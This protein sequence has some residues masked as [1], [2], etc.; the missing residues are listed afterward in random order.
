MSIV[1]AIL[2]DVALSY[3]SEDR[4]YVQAVAAELKSR[5]L[6]C[7]YDEYS[8]A[9]LL[10]ENLR[11]HL[12]DVYGGK[13]R[14][15]VI[16]ASKD[17]VRKVWTS[18]EFRTAQA[19][20]IKLHRTYVLPVRIDDTA[21]PDL[22]L[23]VVFVDAKK[24]DALSLAQTIR[25]RLLLSPKARPL[26]LQNTLL[27]R[28][29]DAS[30]QSVL[31]MGVVAGAALIAW[32]ALIGVIDLHYPPGGPNARQV[33]Y[34]AAVN[35]SVAYLVLFPVAAALLVSA[36]DEVW[37]VFEYLEER[38]M[39]RTRSWVRPDTP[40]D[41]LRV[42]WL[43]GN[44]W[45]RWFVLL[46]CTVVP[47]ILMVEWYLNN[48]RRLYKADKAP[49]IN[50]VDWGL[51]CNIVECTKVQRGL[52]VGLDFFAFAAEAF[53]VAILLVFIVYA[54]DLARVLTREARELDI[55]IWPTLK[56]SD[57]RRGFEEFEPL[58]NRTLIV[59]LVGYLLAYVVRLENLYLTS[60]LPETPTQ[61]TNG[62]LPV[63]EAVRAHSLS[64]FVHD[65][66]STIWTEISVRHQWSVLWQLDG[67][68][69]RTT[70][71]GVGALILYL[72]A[73]LIVLVT[74]WLL[75]KRAKRTATL[76]YAPDDAVPRFGRA[77]KQEEAAEVAEMKVWPLGWLALNELLASTALA[78]ASLI[79]YRLGVVVVPLA[80]T[81]LMY[82]GSRP[83]RRIKS[84]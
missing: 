70:M 33:G 13:S 19:A 65:E 24:T 6:V 3:A 18:R 11:E 7:F 68:T 67:W 43:Q 21:V 79:W 75:A 41:A 76:Y 63:V 78:L 82:R 32:S 57:P 48:Y 36:L 27:R 58:L 71:S 69:K 17:Y 16:F 72:I 23:D 60:A 51:A 49:G 40:A 1:A 14:F 4:P 20:A 10:G 81:Y 54:A 74:V 26:F 73:I 83:K 50:D 66:L 61:W 34:G 2:Y 80:L 53:Y 9:A 47:A 38:G 12:E 52:N 64:E 15:A 46:F 8:A 62:G 84:A 77:T 35:W 42:A 28:L 45:R 37:C 5:G 59:V 25:Q 44:R 29:L 56:S 30:W 31:L 39:Y 22:D 55:E